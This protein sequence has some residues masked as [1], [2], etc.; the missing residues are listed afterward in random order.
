LAASPPAEFPFTDNPIAGA[1]FW[2][3][4]VTALKIAGSYLAQAV[5]PWRLSAD[6]SYAQI[7]LGIGSAADWI[8]A[9][10]AM[11]AAAGVAALWRRHRTVSF[12]SG[13]A[14]IVFLPTSNLLFP[15]GTIRADRFLYLPAAGL[16]GCVVLAMY[17]LGRRARS[18]LVAPVI[19]VLT[20]G[21]FAVRTWARNADWRDELTLASADLRTSPRSFKLHRLMAT[22]LAAADPSHAN[23]D[24]VVEEIDK[25]V[26]ILEPLPDLRNAP[27]TYQVAGAAYLTKGERLQAT[28]ATGAETA[29][30]RARE[31]LSKCVR[32]YQA[33]DRHREAR[34]G[35][36]AASVVAR[37]EPDAYLLLSAV[38]QRLGNTDSALDAAR[39]AQRL[40]PRNPRIYARI[41]DSLLARGQGD[42]AA[43]ALMEGM[44]L[45]A[46][47]DL[48]SYLVRL[49]ASSTDPANCTLLRNPGGPAINPQCRTVRDHVCA[50][51]PDVLRSLIDHGEQ[52]EAMQKKQEFLSEYDC[53]P[54]RL[55]QTIPQGA[56]G[57]APAL[58]VP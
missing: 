7:T 42:G 6:Y 57:P 50:A 4:R 24:R 23:I 28:G 8:L 54:A 56:V 20:I 55:N 52:Q 49:Y 22:L 38:Q 36:P 35:M 30:G 44:L 31:L 10:A 40:A 27:E 11:L 13:F 37:S 47:T 3:G 46:D 29:Y 25:S 18:P 32:I 19:L 45:T 51:A 39:V 9:A 41:A 2:T 26:A 17:A 15:I 16:M 14:V 34:Y 1:G 33:Y 5:W 48:R 12:L 21:G 53:A 43:V 58:Q